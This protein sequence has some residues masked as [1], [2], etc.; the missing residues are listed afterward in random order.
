MVIVT[1]FT[2]IS[3]VYREKIEFIIYIIEYLGTLHQRPIAELVGKCH[4]L[5]SFEQVCS[6]QILLE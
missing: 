2:Y 5:G 4:P 3:C 1:N 6:F